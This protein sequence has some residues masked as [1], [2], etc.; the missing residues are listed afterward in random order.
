MTAL[1]ASGYGVIYLTPNTMLDFANG[2]S[3][4]FEMSTERLSQ[5]D[6][7]DVWVTPYE[8]N[9][10]LPFNAGDVDL[11][12]APRTGVHVD[13]SNG[14][15]AWT[16]GTIHNYT[17]T[18]L[19]RGDDGTPS[20]QSGIMEGTNQ[21]ATRQTF[22]LTLT[23][24]HIR[25]E[26]LASATATALVFFDRDVPDLGFS[27]GVVQL[28]HHSYN[29]TKD[30]SGVPGTWHWDNVQVSPSVP[31][32]MINADRRYT[33]GGV[34]NFESPAPAGASLRFSGICKVLVN[35][36]AVTP[37]R[38]TMKNEHMSSYFVPIAVGTQKVDVRFADDGWYTTGFGCIAKDFA[39][40]TKGSR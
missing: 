39:I 40:W 11:Q 20:L 27:Q 6:W 7:P 21:S 25:M 5:R 24:T 34:V 23:R 38:P 13:S 2:G 17:E 31:F 14:Q 15:G 1:N 19:N 36:Q 10:A 33:T 18:T 4:T 37:A 26:R 35:G 9:L 28:G 8:E 32:R 22:K 30:N 16:V 3:V 12:G 29:P